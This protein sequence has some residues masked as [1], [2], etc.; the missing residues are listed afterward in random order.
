MKL[1]PLFYVNKNKLYKLS[2]NSEVNLS[3]LKKIEI[4][5]AKVEIEEESYNEE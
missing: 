3:S 1:E 4:S 5:W 2:D